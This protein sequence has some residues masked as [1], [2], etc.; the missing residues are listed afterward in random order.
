MPAPN[1]QLENVQRQLKERSDGLMRV[2]W[3]NF[4]AELRN[5]VGTGGLL[6]LLVA[7]IATG[8]LFLGDTENT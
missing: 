4:F 8:G 3:G 7:S 2:A 5:A 6:V 1:A